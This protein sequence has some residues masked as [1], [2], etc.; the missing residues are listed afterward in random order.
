MVSDKH[1]KLPTC[2]KIAEKQLSLKLG[3][4]YWGPLLT[5]PIEGELNNKIFSNFVRTFDSLMAS[6]TYSKSDFKVPWLDKPV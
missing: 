4:T 5:H 3:N 1:I 2:P 6:L